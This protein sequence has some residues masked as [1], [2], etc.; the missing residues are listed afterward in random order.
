VSIKFEQNEGCSGCFCQ[1]TDHFRCIYQEILLTEPKRQPDTEQ[2]WVKIALAGLQEKIYLSWLSLRCDTFMISI[3]LSCTDG[4]LNV[5][6]V[7]RKYTY[8]GKTNINLLSSNNSP[9]LVVS[10][11]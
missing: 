8:K 7:A 2:K 1:I 6:Y 3:S 10:H 9:N 4:Q 5:P 11:N